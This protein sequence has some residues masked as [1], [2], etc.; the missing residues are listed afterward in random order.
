[1]RDKADKAC[2]RPPIRHARYRLTT[3][4]PAVITQPEGILQKHGV[5]INVRYLVTSY[6]T[7]VIAHGLQSVHY[8]N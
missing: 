6:A 5:D 3:Y 8:F 1:M 2:I 7:Q 4:R